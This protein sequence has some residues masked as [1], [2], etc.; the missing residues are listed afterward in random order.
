MRG[1]EHL[2]PA[3]IFTFLTRDADGPSR[4]MDVE[5][6]PLGG[7]DQTERVV[8]D[9]AVSWIATSSHV[10]RMKRAALLSEVYTDGDL[11]EFGTADGLRGS[12]GVK[13]DR[14]IISDASG[15]IWLWLNR[16]I[17]VVDPA[18]VAI[19]GIQSTPQIQAVSVDN[20]PLDMKGP[21]RVPAGSQRMVFGFA[22]MSLSLPER[23]RY[24]YYLENYLAGLERTM[25]NEP[26]ITLLV[27]NAGVG[28]TL[29]LLA[30]NVEDMSRMI[31]L[32]VNAP[33]R[34]TCAV[35]PAMLA[36]VRHDHQPCGSIV[37][38]A[39][40]LLNGVY[41]A[42]KAF[43]LP[44]SR[45]LQHE[46]ANTS[47]RVQVLPGATATDFWT[48]AGKRVEPTP[49]ADRNAAG[50]MV[51][52]ALAGMDQGEFATIPSLPDVA[53]WDTYEAARNAMLPGLS[54]TVAASR[55]K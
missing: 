30:S 39:P 7:D 47:V 21:V 37:A 45:S 23:I 3:A 43:I 15:R 42:T 14:S 12:E 9:P 20:A 53:Q 18:R 49:P 10:L 27:N 50:E 52:A 33:M 13:L 4:E 34:L 48:I 5:L 22:G 6:G 54:L 55:Y 46:L 35:A 25:R 26:R 40:E 19:G 1:V 2:G 41:S 51:D 16:G 29:P 31:A 8:R 24:R 38:V 36:R 44:F 32:N 28:A 17:S 11:R